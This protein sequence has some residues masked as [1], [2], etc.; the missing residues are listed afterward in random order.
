M[1]ANRSASS[2]ARPRTGTGSLSPSNSGTGTFRAATSTSASDHPGS[3]RVAGELASRPTWS[4]RFVGS[5][6]A[7]STGIPD[8]NRSAP[9][10]TRSPPCRR[11]AGKP[12]PRTARRGPTKGFRGFQVLQET[13]PR[14]GL[15]CWCT[16]CRFT[17]TPHPRSSHLR[18]CSSDR[19]H[20]HR[21]KPAELRVGELDSCERV[22]S[23][24]SSLVT[25]LSE[26]SEP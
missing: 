3:R 9:G 23:T 24:A 21:N 7:V 16:C 26:T 14:P 22:R 2:S 10:G 1:F 13:R 17:R 5:A 20:E 15:F 18:S 8:R 6:H 4:R 25:S 11:D 12:A 19:R